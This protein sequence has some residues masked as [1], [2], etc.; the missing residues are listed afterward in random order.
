MEMSANLSVRERLRAENDTLLKE[1]QRY[2]GVRGVPVLPISAT[3]PTEAQFRR[4]LN[5]GTSPSSRP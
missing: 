2:W 4:L 5:A 1:V 3:E